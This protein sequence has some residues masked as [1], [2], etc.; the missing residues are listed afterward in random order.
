MPEGVVHQGGDRSAE[1]Q[2]TPST[3]AGGRCDTRRSILDAAVAHRCRV[4]AEG[5]SHGLLLGLRGGGGDHV[6]G[7]SAQVD[8]GAPIGVAG[9]VGGEQEVFDH[10]TQPPAV[11]QDLARLDR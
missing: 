6:A 7:E 1:R 9:Q 4:V 3:V 8:D 11:V 2:S 5:Q 10:L